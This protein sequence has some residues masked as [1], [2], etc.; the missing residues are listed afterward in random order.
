MSATLSSV[1]EYEKFLY[2]L[3]ST[4]PSIKVSTLVLKRQWQTV[5]ILEGEI[6]F[7][8]DIRHF[9]RERIDFARGRILGYTYDVWKGTEKIYW[10]DSQDHPNDPALLGTR[11]HHKHVPPNIKHHRIP[12]PHLSF[13]TPN[14]PFLIQEIVENILK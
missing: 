7:A 11:P 12:A 4:F 2:S 10:Y 8:P 9:A 6:L 13:T 14:L 3:Q 1:E 5:A